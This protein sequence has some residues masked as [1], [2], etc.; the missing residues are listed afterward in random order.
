MR[1]NEDGQGLVYFWSGKYFKI[2][3]LFIA[4][5]NQ[6]QVCA[7]F[8]TGLNGNILKSHLNQG[9]SCDGRTAENLSNRSVYDITQNFA[10]LSP[11]WCYDRIDSADQMFLDF[12][13]YGEK[14]KNPFNARIYNPQLQNILA[15]IFNAAN[16]TLVLKYNCRSAAAVLHDHNKEYSD[17]DTD[18][19]RRIVHFDTITIIATQNIAYAYFSDNI[20]TSLCVW[21]FVIATMFEETGHLTG[22]I[23]KNTFIRLILGSW[24]L[25]S[26]T[27]TNCYN[28]I[29]ISDLNAPLDSSRPTLFDHLLC[30]R[31]EKFDKSKILQRMMVYN[32]R[33]Q[34]NE[35]LLVPGE[36]FGKY[37]YDRIGW[38]LIVLA[39]VQK[40]ND[41]DNFYN[42][43]EVKPI[44]ELENP[45]ALD[46]FMM[47]PIVGKP[48]SIVLEDAGSSPSVLASIA[49]LA[50][51]LLPIKVTIKFHH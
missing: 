45:F 28:G 10:I 39:L 23:E 47:D 20:T 2:S 42:G 8:R 3:V 21:L 38:Y 5:E 24:C 44:L 46:K 43:R 18:D 33:F 15:I 31:T 48:R 1:S 50:D 35:T 17:D 41:G 25:M 11:P 16:E 19:Y 6:L 7:W 29:M 14:D 49:N 26:V 51:N 4:L 27:L 32:N 9:L 37:G 40:D 30:E 12:N 13:I 22:K 34:N 36:G